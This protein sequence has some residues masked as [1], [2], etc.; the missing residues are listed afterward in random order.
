M[1]DDAKKTRVKTILRKR[2]LT[3]DQ[4][5]YSTKSAQKAA[6]DSDTLI[7]EFILL[8]ELTGVT[9]HISLSDAK[10]CLEFVARSR[11]SRWRLSGDTVNWVQDK[12]REL[13]NMM[14]HVS[15]GV[16]RPDGRASLC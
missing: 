10:E 15:A 14:R 16:M 2:V 5:S 1:L 3:P 13:K 9:K 7:R 12:S 6:I 4:W 8:S 11:E